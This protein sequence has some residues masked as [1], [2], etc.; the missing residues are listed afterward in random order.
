MCQQF[1]GYYDI[2]QRIE[3]H[4]KGHGSP[5]V[6]LG[7]TSARVE[8]AFEVAIRAW[9][10]AHHA[11]RLEICPEPDCSCWT[12]NRRRPQLTIKRITMWET[13]ELCKPKYLRS[14]V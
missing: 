6:A 13:L 4:R 9:P 3:T 2:D 8:L 1:V 12:A 14:V 11:A 5:L 10:G 7:S